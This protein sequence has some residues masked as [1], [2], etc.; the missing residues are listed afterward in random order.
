MRETPPGFRLTA[1]G[2]RRS[3]TETGEEARAAALTCGIFPPKI[4]N[5]S[6]FQH[7]DHHVV[8]PRPVHLLPRP[9]LR[10]VREPGSVSALERA[11]AAGPAGGHLRLLRHGELK[12]LLQEPDAITTFH[13]SVFFSVRR[14]MF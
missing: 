10:L 11:E 6:A 2:G 1:G 7:Q 13:R 12:V 3:G 14:E 4:L 5:G 9:G 8:L